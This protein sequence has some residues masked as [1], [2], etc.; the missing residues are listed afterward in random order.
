MSGMM[1]AMMDRGSAF[2]VRLGHD[3][4]PIVE[5]IREGDLRR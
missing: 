2:L 4:Q 5:L 3:N 1:L